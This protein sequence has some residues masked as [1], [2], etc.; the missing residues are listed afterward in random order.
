[1]ATLTTGLGQL[2]RRQAL[3]PLPKR[4][5]T[6]RLQTT[7]GTIPNPIRGFS[8]G[9]GKRPRFSQRL[10]EALRNSKIQWY[11]IPVGL[12]IGFLGLVQFYKVS[13]REREK[14][15]NAE[16]GE[17]G[18]GTP[19]KRPRVKL[20]GPWQV[21]VMSTLPLKAMSRLWGKF[22]ELTIP[23]YLRVP[24]FKLYS[25]IFGVKYENLF[26]TPPIAHCTADTDSLQPRRSCR[27]RPTRIPESCRIFLSKAETGLKTAAS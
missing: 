9:S 22:N 12:G 2:A 7:L 16:N 3:G 23:Y 27:R 25:F 15:Q 26:I 1:M 21:R 18:E 5:C 24:G 13:S 19:A 17:F 6:R 14:Q 8:S 4:A 11:Q 10:A 20:E